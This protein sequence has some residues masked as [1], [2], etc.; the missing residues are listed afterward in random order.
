MLG[1]ATMKIRTDQ[2]T[3]MA[4]RLPRRALMRGVTAGSAAAMLGAAARTC[5]GGGCTG[6]SPSIRAG[7]SSSSTTSR[8]TRFSCP[9]STVSPM[10]ARA[11]LRLS[12]DWVGNLRCG[13]DGQRDEHRDRR[14]SR[15]HRHPDRRSQRVRPARRAG[16]RSRHPGVQLQRRC[17]AWRRQQAARLYRAG[18]VFVGPVDG[19]AHRQTGRRGR[20]RDLYRHP[21]PAEFAA[22][23]RRR[24]GRDQEIRRQDQRRR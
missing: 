24:D 8:P 21:G 14:Q 12:V 1:R 3:M 5:R 19:R 4:E 18:F 16:A 15:W 20:G 9:A 13:A 11:R 6:P 7:N 10:P 22:A 23:G 17:A 2:L